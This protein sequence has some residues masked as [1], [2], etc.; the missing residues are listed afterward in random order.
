M[1]L[2]DQRSNLASV[3]MDYSRKRKPR[4]RDSTK[5]IAETL[6]KWKEYNEKLDS[7]DERGKPVRKVPAKGSKK[8]CMKGKGGPENAR[9]NYRGV[10]QRTWGK[11][12]AEIREPNRGSRL[13]LG[14][15]GN[16]IEAALAYDEAAKSMY[17]PCA[18]LNLPNYRAP[19]ESSHESSSLPTTSVS[20]STTT[21]GLSEVSPPADK[22]V[23]PILDV[24]EEDGEGESVIKDTKF[25]DV[26]TPPRA[27][28]EEPK[29]E[30]MEALAASIR[31]EDPVKTGAFNSKD[32]L[33][34]ALPWDEMFYID[35]MLSALN[36][37]T[38]HGSGSQYDMRGINGGQS[39]NSNMQPSE[40]QYEMHNPDVKVR[41][42]WQNVEQ[43]T[44]REVDYGFDFL[45]PGREEDYQLTMNDLGFLDLD[46]LGI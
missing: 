19:K 40:F 45:E 30:H 43:T 23:E 38:V 13:W 18:R 17:G 20:E 22:N 8:G 35:E 7:L 31:A 29:D 2:L 3:P 41:G 12:V 4:R 27:V 11:W 6:A 16:A 34:D 44:S 10:R 28:K 32:E 42:S 37:G 9:C 25:E 1:A 14:T 5:D 39:L 24:K 36:S 46:D 33:L 21:S 15:F 26:C